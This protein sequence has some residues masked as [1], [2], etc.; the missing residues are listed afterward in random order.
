V[1]KKKEV[2][3]GISAL[4]EATHIEGYEVKEWSI[5]QFSALYPYLKKVM[6]TL[7]ESGATADNI[8]DYL[9]DKFTEV[10]EAF[11]PILPELLEI[12]LNIPPSEV[13]TISMS[14]ASLLGVAIVRCNISHLSSF[15]S[16]LQGDTV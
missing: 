2:K 13:D 7:Q 6:D 15:L 10:L 14:K 16:Q 8:D 1:T 12:S 5:R 4:L 3:T 9:G 11:I